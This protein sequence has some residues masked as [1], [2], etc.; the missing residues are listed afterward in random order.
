MVHVIKIK[1]IDI[2]KEAEW[3]KIFYR[4]LA[5]LSNVLIA[6]ESENVVALHVLITFLMVLIEY[7]R[8]AKARE[9]FGSGRAQSIFI[10]TR[11]P[12]RIQESD[13]SKK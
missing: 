11:I 12:N 6:K 5:K 7:A 1:Q 4:L 8:L 13:D 9:V 10:S 3:K 2:N